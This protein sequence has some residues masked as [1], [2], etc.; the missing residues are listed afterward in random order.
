MNRNLKRTV[1]LIAMAG[2]VGCASALAADNMSQ[3]PTT[4]EKVRERDV[5]THKGLTPQ[6]AH[7]ARLAAEGYTNQEIGARLLI[8]HRTVEFHLRKVFTK[9]GVASRKQLRDTL[10]RHA[11]SAPPK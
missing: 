5:A 9:L 8:S 1:A 11:R 6:E 7:I 4:G 10:P 2:A 3:I